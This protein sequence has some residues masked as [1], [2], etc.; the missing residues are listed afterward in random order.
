MF[1]FLLIVF[2]GAL[3]LSGAAAQIIL[4]RN[5]AQRLRELRVTVRVD[6]QRHTSR[7]SF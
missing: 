7:G 4:Y 3:V 1:D 6:T 2:P 5:H